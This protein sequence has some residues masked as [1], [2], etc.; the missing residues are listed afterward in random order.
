M[1]DKLSLHAEILR[2]L[3]RSLVQA[4]GDP[5]EV[6][7]GLSGEGFGDLWRA[8]YR[9]HVGEPTFSTVAGASVSQLRRFRDGLRETVARWDGEQRPLIPTD[10][11]TTEG[12]P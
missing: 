5:D 7:K 1:D 10:A 11:T 9:K 6:E 8:I 12:S 2:L 3:A 4:G